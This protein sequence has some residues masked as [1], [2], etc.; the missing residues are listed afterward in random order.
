MSAPED[1]PMGFNANNAEQIK[2]GIHIPVIAIDRINT[3]EIAED[4]LETGKADFVSIS[5]QS[6][7]EPESPNKVKEGKISEITPCINCLQFCMGYMTDPKHL[8]ACC[9]V[10]PRVGHEGEY[11][12]DEAKV[13]KNVMVVGSGPAGLYAAYVAAKRGH[14][15]SL[16]EAQDKFGGQ[17]RIATLP[18]C[19][20]LLT[21]P[22]RFCLQEGRKYGV[23][24]HLNTTVTK[25]LV[26]EKKP[27]VVIL[28][29]GAQQVK[30]HIEGIDGANVLMANDVIEGKVK[31]GRHNL[32]AGAGLVGL[33]CADFLRE[34]GGRVCMIIDR[35]PTVNYGVFGVGPPPRA[36]QLD[37]NLLYPRCLHREVYR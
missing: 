16:Y 1:V 30:P 22:L 13:K 7:A 32:I 15:V 28:A 11:K 14:N 36:P 20:S 19:K 10:N 23:E 5:R 24:H 9:L 12:F 33:E 26:E 3:P 27:D 35:L 6:L 4:I 2:E 21:G 29:T 34:R 8:T 25:E 17:F 37:R 18:P 31:A